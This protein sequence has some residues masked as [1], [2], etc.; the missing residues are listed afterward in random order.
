MRAPT[1]T[2]WV[3]AGNT[4][5]M[6]ITLACIPPSIRMLLQWKKAM[7]ART[8]SYADCMQSDPMPS[9]LCLC[10]HFTWIA[11]CVRRPTTH[12]RG[13]HVGR[14][15][16][17]CS[18]GRTRQESSPCDRRHRRGRPKRSLGRCRGSRPWPCGPQGSEFRAGKQEGWGQYGCDLSIM[19]SGPVTS[20]RDGTCT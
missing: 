17:T 3:G 18:I 16:R 7:E 8:P 13:A 9:H 2:P 1:H 12:A 5:L 14:I 4:L 19:N 10:M 11:A 6:S 15:R 20:R